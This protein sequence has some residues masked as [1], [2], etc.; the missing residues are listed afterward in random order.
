[1]WIYEHSSCHF[2]NQ[3]ALSIWI[4]RYNAGISAE[5]LVPPILSDL[6]VIINSPP[7]GSVDSFL[8][9]NRY[10]KRS[11]NV[12]TTYWSRDEWCRLNSDAAELF[13]SIFHSFEAGITNAIPSFKWQKRWFLFKHK[14]PNLNYFI[15]SP[16]VAPLYMSRGTSRRSSR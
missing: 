2:C 7:L 14:F 12:G 5:A 6:N 8:S 9:N 16:V 4:G 3:S 11:R 10:M 15:I 13:A 1:M